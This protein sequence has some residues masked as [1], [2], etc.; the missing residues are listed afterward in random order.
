M[1]MKGI[2]RR[3]LE[4]EHP[5]VSR[6]ADVAERKQAYEVGHK[7]ALC[8]RHDGIVHEQ[9]IKVVL[10]A[11]KDKVSFA[12]YNDDRANS[13]YDCSQLQGDWTQLNVPGKLNPA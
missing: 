4:T 1:W 6:C 8:A 5:E 3:N 10:I 9:I 2:E 7:E 12:N 13:K 11:V